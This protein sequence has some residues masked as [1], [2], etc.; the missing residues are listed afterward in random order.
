MK[1]I[2]L[3]EDHAEVREPLVKLLRHEGYHV[4]GA[5]NG[6]EALALLGSHGADLVLMDLLMPKMGGIALLE[7]LR[8]DIRWERL[9]AI[10]LT[11]MIE[12]SALARARELNVADL[13]F[14]SKFTV[15]DLFDR[16]RAAL[17][18]TAERVPA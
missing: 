3:I 6:T 12:G 9:P 14:K 1:T 18:P 15:E 10:V 13:L 8:R 4:L 17:L 16:V 2:L 5:S 11:G 7:V